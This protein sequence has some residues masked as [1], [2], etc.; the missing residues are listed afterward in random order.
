MNWTELKTKLREQYGNTFGFYNDKYRSGTRRI[1]IRCNGL[2]QT[3]MKQFILKQDPNL[4]V[5]KYWWHP[6]G[7]SCAVECITIHFNE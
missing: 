4:N 1:K 7:S 6:Y 3:E 5:N 2:D